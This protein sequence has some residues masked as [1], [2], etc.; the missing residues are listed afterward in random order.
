MKEEDAVA[1]SSPSVRI[2]GAG[3]G[4][5]ALQRAGT[6]AGRYRWV[7]CGVLFLGITKNYM[8]R[9]VLSVL[10]NPLQAEFGWNEIQYG[11]LVTL[12]QLSYA[13]GMLGMGRV[14]DWLGTRIGYAVAMVFWSIASMSHAAA[15]SFFS[16][17]VARSALGFGEA[18]VFPASLKSVA[19]WFPKKERALATGIFNAGTSVGAMITPLVIPWIAGRLGWRWAFLLTGGLGFAWLLLWLAVYQKPEEH[20][21]CTKEELAYINSDPIPP[22]GKLPWLQL[23]QYRQTWTIAGGKFVIDPIWWFFLFWIPDYMQRAHGLTLGK[24]GPPVFAIYL[25]SDFGSVGGGWISS[26]LIRRGLSINWARKAAMLV[27]AILV[28]PIAMAYR[29]SGLWPA[30]L[31]IGLAA[32]AHQGFSANVLTLASDLFPSRAV[33]SVSGIAGMAGAVG[34][35]LIAE[36]VGHILQWTGSYKIPFFIAASAYTVALLVIHVLSPRLAP[37][38]IAQS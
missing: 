24:I 4:A 3:R 8:D 33:G 20:P 38:E 9:Q 2:G 1:G 10:K 7:I 27:C 30:T 19:E 32:A 5:S 22:P 16:F 36:A 25:I 12:F 31:L 23:L 11:H 13:A 34:G 15:G 29:V 37:A 35:M 21:Q 6:F 18:G 26:S 14:I 28:L 17:A